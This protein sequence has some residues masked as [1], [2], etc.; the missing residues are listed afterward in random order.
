LF[1]DYCVCVCVCAQLD[2]LSSLLHEKDNSYNARIMWNMD[3]LQ[4]TRHVRLISCLEYANDLL[5]NRN[6]S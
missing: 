4:N 6:R 5:T 2:G 3:V 1:V